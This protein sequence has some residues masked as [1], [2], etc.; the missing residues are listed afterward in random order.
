MEAAGLKLKSVKCQLM[1]TSVPN[2]GHV[3]TTEGVAT[4]P[5]KIR[6]VEGWPTLNNLRDLRSFLGLCSFFW[7][8]IQG[9]SMFAFSTCLGI[10]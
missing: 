2:L 8:L 9:F 3:V 1:K 7:R 5:E 10:S 4:D 6:A